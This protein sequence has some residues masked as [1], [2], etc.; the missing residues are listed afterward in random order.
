MLNV[1]GKLLQWL[2]TILEL[3]SF[4]YEYGD[5]NAVIGD[6]SVDLKKMDKPMNVDVEAWSKH[7]LADGALDR[8]GP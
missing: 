1:N 5:W 3:L 7:K 2:P 6:T 4:S 8:P